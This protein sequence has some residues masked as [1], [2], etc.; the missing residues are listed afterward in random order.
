MQTH[1][2]SQRN[3]NSL[4]VIHIAPTPFFSNR[5]CHIRILN[6]ID[7]LKK[8]DVH[9]ILCTYGLGDDIPGINIRRIPGIPGYT[10]KEAGF[11]P[12]KFIA[13]ILLFF[14]VLR[15]A[16][17]ENATI[18]HGHLHEGGLIGWAVKICLFWR[19]IF[20][21]MDI[22][23][24]LSGELQSHGTFTQFPFLLRCFYFVE[25]LIALLPQRV[26][27]SSPSSKD[28]ITNTCKVNCNRVFL[29]G[30][31]VPD[32]FFSHQRER[33]QQDRHSIPE[34]KKIIIYTGGLLPGK[35][36]NFLLEAMKIVLTARDDVHFI[37]IGYPKEKVQ[38]YT[39]HNS[40]GKS[41]TLPGEVSYKHLAE[42]LASAD[43][44]I[45]PKPGGAGE[46]S[47]KILHYMASGLPVI[48]FATANNQSFLTDQCF[49]AARESSKDLAQAIHVALDSEEAREK[50]GKI[51]RDRAK[52]KFSLF[53]AGNSL[54]NLY[55]EM[56]TTS[57][58]ASQKK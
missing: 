3:T 49:Y 7:G 56:I 48:C 27:C 24:S 26:V 29:L 58:A 53:A 52:E 23:G 31:V 22:Q 39:Y 10:K 36:V 38:A 8:S 47:G 2:T 42:W 16:Y 32:N 41:I 40:I 37:L 34:N 21:V 6:E 12:F 57:N 50:Y 20:V 5:G 19:K 51:G 33:K 13:D 11:S 43:A 35:G 17:K 15:T 9:V 25:K 54:K 28:F 46:A 44:A 1:S 45:D 55:T 14:L 18:L 30:D 4:S